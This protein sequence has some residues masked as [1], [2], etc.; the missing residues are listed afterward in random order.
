MRS[1]DLS[2]LEA[3]GAGPLPPQRKLEVIHLDTPAAIDIRFTTSELMAH[4][5]V[6]NQRDL[7]EATFVITGTA[8]LE[9]KSLKLYLASW[10]EERILA[11]D[12]A[13]SIAD[14]LAAALGDAG[15]RISVTLDQNVRGGIAISVTATRAR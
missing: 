9:S 14:D 15:M 13:N 8:T 1:S 5:P 11:E 12:L 10:D 6:T 4:C 2:Q 3:L 7:Y